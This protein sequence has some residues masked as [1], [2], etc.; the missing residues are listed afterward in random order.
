MSLLDRS[1]PTRP[2]PLLPRA[3]TWERWRS[4][5]QLGAVCRR[6]MFGVLSRMRSDHLSIVDET[7]DGEPRIYLLGEATTSRSAVAGDSEDRQHSRSDALSATATITDIRAWTAMATEGSIGLGRGYFEGWWDSDDPTTVLRIVIRNL[8]SLDELRNRLNRVSGGITDP[9]RR[10]IPRSGKRRD[11]EDIA[12]HY[13]LGNEFFE[14][15]LDESMTYSSGVYRTP[16]TSL[17]EASALKNRRLLEKLAVE[18]E[19]H[20]LEIGT[21]WGGFAIQAAGEVGCRV[22]TT[23]VS[24]EQRREAATRVARAGLADQVTILDNDWRDLGG[25]HDRVVSIEMIEAV[26]WRDY[27]RYFAT[28]EDCLKPDGLVGIQAIC[29]ADR[30]FGRTKNTE[31]FIRR[32]VF[33]GGFLPSIGAI[34]KAVSAATRL[35]IIDLED[36]SRHYAETLRRWRENLHTRLA[37][38]QD[39]GLD[40]RFCRLWEFYLAYCESAFVE[41]HVS[42]FQIVLAGR[43][44]RP[45]ELGVRPV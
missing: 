26:D 15:I 7:A 17:A 1:D 31:D 23:T 33:P 13:D 29:V 38:V 11:R 35:Q 34:N 4:N 25:L 5:E 32:F 28:V 44:W 6:V 21:G 41:R 10:R 2:R 20:I 9:I 39:L 3:G 36:L 42:V 19:H 22:T 14:L 40:E 24:A 18:P 37:D 16:A 27:E 8:E 45:A 43:D 30:R 12:A